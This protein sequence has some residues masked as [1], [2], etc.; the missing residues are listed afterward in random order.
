MQTGLGRREFVLGLVP[1]FFRRPGFLRKPLQVYAGIE[2]HVLHHP[3]A[4]RRNARRFLVIHG[5]EDT[6]RDVLTSYIH[7]HDGVAFLVTSKSREVE[8][9]GVKI[10]PNRMF[11]RVGAELSIRKLTPGLAEDRITA[12]LD[13][14][15]HPKHG[16][17][18]FLKDLLPQKRGRLMALHNNR[19]YS[20]NDEIA[21]SDQT[22]IKQPDL[23]RHFFLCTSPR[24][25]EILKQSPYNVVL[26]SRPDPDDGSLSRLCARRGIR[27]VNLECAIGDYQAQMERLRWMDDRLP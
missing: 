20:V 21:D 23:P 19:D 25:Y 22:S 8:I 7:D 9:N 11:S 10:D 26:Q 3:A 6:A 4:P 5:D 16:R 2:F 12:T 13:F 15:D 17:E 24:D 14:L 1:A 18:H 27:Y